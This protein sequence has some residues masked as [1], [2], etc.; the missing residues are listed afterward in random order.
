MRKDFAN[1]QLIQIVFKLLALGDENDFE[2]LQ[3]SPGMLHSKC[4][5]F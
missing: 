5:S 2:F 1:L 3:E 4:A